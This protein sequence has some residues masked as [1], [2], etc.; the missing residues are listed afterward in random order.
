MSMLAKAFNCDFNGHNREVQQ[1]PIGLCPLPVSVCTLC[2]EID[3]FGL[4]GSLD[5]LL[6]L[7]GCG[8]E[9]KAEKWAAKPE[10]ERADGASASTVEQ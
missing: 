2:G 9:G 8:E 7:M 5:R 3:W 6:E 1:D 10:G 4:T